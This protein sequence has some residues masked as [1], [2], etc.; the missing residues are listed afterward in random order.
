M[1]ILRTGSLEFQWDLFGSC[2][3]DLASQEKEW[4]WVRTVTLSPSLKHD[5]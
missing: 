2:T 5:V 4:N 3:R 1:Y